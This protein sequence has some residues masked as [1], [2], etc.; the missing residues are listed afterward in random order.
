MPV[1]DDSW[2]NEMC[3][4]SVAFREE[5]EIVNNKKNKITRTTEKKEGGVSSQAIP[6]NIIH[7]SK[8]G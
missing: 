7:P 8:L 6:R 1:K 5:C 3:K 4:C 2:L